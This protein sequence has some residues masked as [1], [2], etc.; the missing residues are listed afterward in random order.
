MTDTS[1]LRVGMTV[2]GTGI[3]VGDVRVS[4]V[5]YPGDSVGL[6][7][8]TFQMKDSSDNDVNADET[9]DPI[10]LTFGGGMV[11]PHHDLFHWNN[12]S[13]ERRP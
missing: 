11:E 8:N 5:Y 12:N 1:E 9:N 2:A 10:T 4:F 3:P 6:N 7:E 13:W